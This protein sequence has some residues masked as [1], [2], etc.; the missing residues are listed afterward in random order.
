MPRSSRVNG[1]GTAYTPYSSSSW[2][3]AC[4]EEQCFAS[5]KGLQQYT[6]L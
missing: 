2:T 6:P 5:I 1:K 4:F 3:M